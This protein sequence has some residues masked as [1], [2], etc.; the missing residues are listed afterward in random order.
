MIKQTTQLFIKALI[1][2][3]ILNFILNL[4][5][6]TTTKSLE[7]SPQFNGRQILEAPAD[8]NLSGAFDW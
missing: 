5:S 8:K 6:V 3:L 2:G 7:N 1:I 4:V